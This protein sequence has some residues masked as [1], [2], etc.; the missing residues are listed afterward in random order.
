MNMGRC[1]KPMA[2][3]MP[4]ELWINGIKSATFL[5]TPY[6]LEDLA[7]GHMM[8]KGL[9]T[10]SEDVTELSL[11]TSTYVI[12]ART[13]T[14]NRQPLY[15]VSEMILSGCSAVAEFSGQ[16]Y[17]LNPV[18][19]QFRASLI[20]IRDLG[21]HMVDLS[22][23]Y[24]ETGGVH[25]ALLESGGEMLVREDIGRH[26]A[27]DKAI[28]AAARRGLSLTEAILITT[29]R[30]SLDMSLKAASVSVPVIGTLKYPSD[31]GVR[32]AA[33]YRICIAARILSERPLIYTAEETIIE[34]RKGE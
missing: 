15:G 17:Q 14:D 5:C 26:N 12:S 30:I 19:S 33:H 23:I 3:E 20:H 2:V 24:R 22:E 11:D 9:I 28:G 21:R 6:D 32:L 18:R 31:L 4:A 7:V 10:S 1:E 13:V 29:G 34:L 27:L 16:I 8:T 25:A